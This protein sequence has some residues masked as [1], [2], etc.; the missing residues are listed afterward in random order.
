VVCGVT[1]GVIDTQCIFFSIVAVDVTFNNINAISVATEMRKWVSFALLYICKIFC[2]VVSSSNIKYH[3]IVC[4]LVLVTRHL[5]IACFLH[6]ITLL[7]VACLGLLYFSTL[8]QKRLDF[9]EEIFK[10]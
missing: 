3:E 6:R 5:K 9:R 2:I 8:S 7:S 1:I 4:I 10:N